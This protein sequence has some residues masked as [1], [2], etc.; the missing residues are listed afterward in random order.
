MAKIVMSQVGQITSDTLFLGGVFVHKR[1]SS[2][3]S[4]RKRKG[5]FL[6]EESENIRIGCGICRIVRQAVDIAGVAGQQRSR[7]VGG[8]HENRAGYLQRK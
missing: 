4:R 8:S 5:T 6:I 1:L 7:T 3:K 2:N